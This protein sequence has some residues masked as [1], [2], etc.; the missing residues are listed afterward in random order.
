MRK[1]RMVD[2]HTQ[3]L[4]IK[5]EIDSAIL[6][7]INSS[8]F[9]KSPVVREFENNLSGYLDAKYVIACGN[10]TDALQI[11]LMALDLKPGDEVITPDFTFIATIEV[12]T[13]LGLKPVIVDVDPGTFNIDP[14]AIESA[15]TKRTKAI[16]PVHLFGQCADME[17]IT[18]IASKHGIYII[19][20]AA[21][22]MGCKYT[23]ANNKT[24]KAGTIGHLGC[25][26][27]FPSKSLACYGDG[28][29]VISNDGEL[30]E[31]IRTI[32]NHGMKVKY[33]H[34][35]VGVNSRLD[36]IQAAVLNVKLKYLE[37]YYRARHMAA[38]YYDNAFRDVPDIII[39]SRDDKSGHI[40]HQYTI[41]L[42][43]N[44]RDKL[45]EYLESKEIPSMIYYPVPLHLQKAFTRLGYNKGDFPV[46]E[47]L[48]K[49]VISLPMHTEL[50]EE[51]LKYISG[52]VLD[53][54]NK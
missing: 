23:F 4:N 3:Y 9:V 16:I 30:A 34:D 38:E 35:M 31:K 53:F 48:C 45:K 15:I 18:D 51:Q 47:E 24:L 49:T 32:A 7:V 28:G 12:I 40:F 50:D 25:A 43:N 42:R 22:A 21:Q 26:S 33:Y 17:K 41:R 44:D 1:I 5:N 37:E 19:E 2:L 39:P 27:F 11:C 8:A 36:G 6:D 54:I 46:T 10:G 20:D 29:A 14:K 13:L 52:S